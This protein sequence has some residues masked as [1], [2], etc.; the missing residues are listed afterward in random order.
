MSRTSQSAL[1]DKESNVE[2]IVWWK[3]AGGQT[4][5]KYLHPSMAQLKRVLQSNKGK[6][7]QE[8]K[9]LI[10][11]DLNQNK[12][13]IIKELHIWVYIEAYTNEIRHNVVC[14][15]YQPQQTGRARMYKT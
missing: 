4:T 8:Y 12:G 10:I 1:I 7:D 6:H 2:A 9:I 13:D 15:P 5:Q 11:T 3:G 14:L